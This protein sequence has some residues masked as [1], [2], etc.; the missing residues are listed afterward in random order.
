MQN[1]TK[2]TQR[3]ARGRPRSYD[4]DEAAG[5]LQDVFW[6]DGFNAASLDKLAAAA[7]MNR[8]SLYA[9]FGDKQAMYLATVGRF[10]AHMR[11][12]VATALDAPTLR[13]SLDRFYGAAIDLYTS[14]A[15][16]QK[17]CLVLCTATVEA[18][19]NESIR[20]AL[21]GVLADVDSLLTKRLLRAKNEG[22]L[23]TKAKPAALARILAAT[24]H[25][26]AI[27]ARSG[28]SRRSLKR[29]AEDT[30]ALTLAASRSR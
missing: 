7:G 13:Q 12:A 3:R 27:R 17:G 29:L 5:S 16:T 10:A 1:G 19:T 24:L 15:G 30:I 11:L 14:G 28:E 21:M 23:S 2:T 6:I 4:L 20:G 9:A 8:P 26:L 25:S 22:E 18:A